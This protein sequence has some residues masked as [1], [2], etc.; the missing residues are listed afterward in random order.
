ME[1]FTSLLDRLSDEQLDAFIDDE[2]WQDGRWL[3]EP[4]VNALVKSIDRVSIRL[5][6]FT[7][8]MSSPS[9]AYDIDFDEVDA[10]TLSKWVSLLETEYK[11]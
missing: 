5:G 10:E 1:R 9:N 8:S 2:L 4:L 7:V 6:H 3:A 11:D